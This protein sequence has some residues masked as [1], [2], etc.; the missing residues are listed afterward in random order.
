MLFRGVVCCL[1]GLYAVQEGC[2][3]IITCKGY[4]SNSS[5]LVELGWAKV[6][7]NYFLEDGGI[8]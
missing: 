1:G 6:D 3:Q 2:M 7:Q 4:L 8:D 5:I